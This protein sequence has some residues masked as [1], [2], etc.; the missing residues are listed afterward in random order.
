M[1]TSDN[2]ALRSKA[3]D[4]IVAHCDLTRGEA[5]N[6]VNLVLGMLNDPDRYMIGAG[7]QELDRAFGSGSGRNPGYRRNLARVVW[8]AMLDEAR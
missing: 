6:A 4:A 7:Q 8:R 1:K 2:R 5:L 3:I